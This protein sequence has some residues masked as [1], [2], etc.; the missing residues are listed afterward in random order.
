MELGKVYLDERPHGGVI[1]GHRFRALDPQKV[2]ALAASMSA[3]GLQMPISVWVPNDQEVH[4]VAG[5]HR[6]AAAIQLGWDAIDCIHVQLSDIDRRRWE[7]AENLH[8]AELTALERSEHVAEWVRLTEEVQSAQLVSAQ[9]EPKLSQRGRKGEGRPASGIRAAARE[10]G[11][12]KEDARRAVK[13]ASLTE[14]AKETARELRLDDNRSALLAAAAKPSEAQAAALHEIAER[15]RATPVR[16]EDAEWREQDERTLA[17]LLDAWDRAT[18]GAQRE[19]VRQKLS[20]RR[21]A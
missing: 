8:R 21:A 11:I 1:V 12:E 5:A 7:I 16:T 13:V 9:L 10:L 14:E 17:A 18:V 6:L 20:N 19:F 15:G 3:I 4:L 2:D